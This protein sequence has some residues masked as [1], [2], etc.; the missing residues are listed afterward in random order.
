M[1]PSLG[2]LPPLLIMTG[3]GEILRDEQIYLAHKCANPEMY[4]PGD[5]HISESAR[6]QI[7]RFKPTDVQLQI[8]DDLCHV[9]P[10]LSFTRPAKYMYRSIAQFGA[11]ALA[12]AQKTEIEILDDDQISIISSSESDSEGK[13]TPASK[14]AK[15]SETEQPQVGKA[16]DPLPPFKNHMI[17][18]RVDRHGVIRP[19][20]SATELPACNLDPN[21]VG[22]V[23][24]GPVRKWLE[25]RRQWEIR[26]STARAKVHKRRLKEMMAGYQGFDGEAPPPSALAARRKAVGD[27]G[28]KK[29]KKSMGLAL[30]SLWGSKHDE[31]TVQ[32]EEE[33]EK[34][35]ET[36]VTT[37][38]QGQG[39]RSPSD[40][41][42]QGKDVANQRPSTQRSR[43][44]TK[45]VKDEHQT[46]ESGVDANT[47]IGVLM[48]KREGRA[49][50]NAERLPT[51]NSSSLSPYYIPPST[52]VTGKRPILDGIAVPFT[53]DKEAET[54]SMITLTSAMDQ[55]MRVASPT[56]P[57]AETDDVSTTTPAA[58]R[59]G[60]DMPDEVDQ[61]YALKVVAD[62]PWAVSP[63]GDLEG[64]KTPAAVADGPIKSNIKG[65]NESV[66]M[67]VNGSTAA[68]E[69][70]PPLETFVTAQEELPRV[71]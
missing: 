66:E 67:L 22:V 47:S 31:M 70:R 36:K 35:P 13:T 33:A 25:Y 43:S 44:R 14:K 52:G 55:S 4:P 17:R 21:E 27:L 8:W 39:A 26:F 58:L 3:G 37:E 50:Q 5:A 28:A 68:H 57:G 2:G 15:V 54:A 49:P 23:Q 11:W 30:W 65:S 51:P 20:E 62:P 6:E 24:E 59:S 46:S 7:S 61:S 32:R 56:W 1:Q 42:R 16:G 48:A 18:Q 71:Q 12:R 10:T 60:P 63:V 40:L 38:H 34:A 45:L 69:Q 53:L 29:K 9:A 19:L 41:E 64:R